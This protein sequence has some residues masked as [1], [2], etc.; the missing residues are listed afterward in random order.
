[1]SEQIHNPESNRYAHD[2]LDDSTEDV[3]GLGMHAEDPSEFGAIRE[4]VEQAFGSPVE[5]ELVGMIRESPNYV[6]EVSL[7]ARTD[8]LF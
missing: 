2:V 8:A 6:P 5:A 3:R 7:V 4:V 1:M